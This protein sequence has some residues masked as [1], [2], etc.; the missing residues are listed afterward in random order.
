MKAMVYD[1]YGMTDV[2]TL[3]EVKIPVIRDN[4][5]LVKVHAVSVNSWDWD[6]L[7]GKPFLTRIGG[8]LKPKYG[9]SGAG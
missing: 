7:R 3:K 9:H 4:E 5:V 6:L 2:L 8:L 1:R